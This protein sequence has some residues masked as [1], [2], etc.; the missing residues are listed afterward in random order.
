M[1]GERNK[2][3]AIQK[4]VPSIRP[5]FISDMIFAGSLRSHGRRSRYY[6]SRSHGQHNPKNDVSKSAR[7]GKEYREEP[8]D[9][10]NR[11]IKI[12]IIGQAGAH[13]RYLFVSA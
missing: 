3:R 1:P 8:E 2:S 6:S 7:P 4:R 9:S 10:H 12:E 11:G 5:E 13:A